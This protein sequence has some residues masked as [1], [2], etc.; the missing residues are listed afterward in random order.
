MPDCIK[1]FS[2]DCRALVEN[3]SHMSDTERLHRLFELEWEYQMAEYPVAATYHGHSGYN[4]R[5]TDFSFD[6]VERRKS[7][8][9][10]TLQTL[11]SIDRSRLSPDDQLNYDL[12]QWVTSDAIAS[13]RFPEELKPL[14]QFHGDHL[15]IPGVL[16]M[17]PTGTA[18]ECDDFLARLEQVPA[19]LGQVIDLLKEGLAQNVTPPRAVIGELPDQVGSQITSDPAEAPMLQVLR[20]PAPADSTSRH[21]QV[22]KD[23]YS[24]YET[25]ITPRL[26][27][28]RDFLAGEYLPHCRETLACRDLPNGE[29]WYR[30]L[31]RHF[32]T[33]SLTP[34]E[35]FEIGRDEVKRIRS[36]MD[37][38]IKDSD[39]QGS[40]T[41]FTDFLRT[42][43]RFFFD[44]KE[45]LVREYRNI[46][47]RADPELARLFGRLSQLP[48]G[49]KPTPAY[50]EK[51][52]PMGFY[53]PGSLKAGRPGYYLVNTYDLRSR[54]KWEMEALSLHE[55]VPGHHLQIALAQ[56]LADLP[57]FRSHGFI[58]AYLEG[59]ALYAESLGEEMGFY[60]T[61]YTKFGQLTYQMWRAARL[62]VD[63]G[64]HWK[65]WSRQRAIDF[66]I[67]NSG[68]TEHD[69]SVEVDRYIVWPAQAL[70]YKIG[71]I[72]IRTLKSKAKGA[73]DDR[74]DIRAFHDE[75]LRHGALPLSV[76]EELITSWVETVKTEEPI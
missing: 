13:H 2:D 57:K 17:M 7:N 23:A 15:A 20:K 68:K 66:I 3:E 50:R 72:K 47:K 55:A 48:Y 65:G 36:E 40:F 75:V 10:L 9:K 29:E 11:A 21:E 61:P 6:A 1:T 54:P 58:T 16:N 5:W 38:V 33:T 43:D 14:N 70:A 71:E 41:E 42:D 76:L 28:L 31:V 26:K 52:A 24:L 34:E 45:D 44:N 63:V 56:E 74:F 39:F 53:Q 62:V 35:V 59:W 64:L 30:H 27:E 32:T 46:A 12:F 49:V 4:H 69:V 8:T 22:R 51:A 25:A 19:Y 18:R 73:L 60:T 67:E 37:R